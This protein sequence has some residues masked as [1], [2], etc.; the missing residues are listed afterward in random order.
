MYPRLVALI[1][2]AAVVVP[3]CMK[4]GTPDSNSNAR[5]DA[6]EQRVVAE[7]A[8]LAAIQKQVAEAEA[9]AEVARKEAEFQSCRA[10]VKE[11]RAEVERRRATCA[12]DVA[13]RN[14]CLA[15][16]SERTATGGI[17]G[18]GLGLFAAAFTGGAATPWALGGCGAGFGAGSLSADVCPGAMCAATIHS[19]ESVVLGERNVLAYR[20]CGGFVGVEL[21]AGQRVVARGLAVAMVGPGTYGDSAGVAAGDILIVVGD[22]V[23]G[24]LDEVEQALVRVQERQPLTVA[25][26]RKGELFLLTAPASRRTGAGG[27]AH[28]LKLGVELQPGEN[29]E[30]RDGVSIGTVTPASPAAAAGVRE[31]DRLAALVLHGSDE[32]SKREQKI[33]RLADAEMFLED[34]PTGADVTFSVIRA[35][36]PIDLAV[37]LGDRAQEAGL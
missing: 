33:S 20:R 30:F 4:E 13:D 35:E 37:S 10:G 8:K 19:V 17:I 7:Q 21:V 9:R 2:T 27:L 32:R 12:K 25:I 3:A 18:C 6:I 5:L 15:R 23:V 26:I 31:G 36:I 1:G 29:I 14:L 28:T 34:A 22:A 24:T 16:N 11:I